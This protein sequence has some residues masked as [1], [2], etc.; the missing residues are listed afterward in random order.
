M[1]YCYIKF[2]RYKYILNVYIYND[3]LVSINNI[4]HILKKMSTFRSKL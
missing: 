3:E 1:N 4:N 2:H